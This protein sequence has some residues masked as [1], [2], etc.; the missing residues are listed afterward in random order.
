MTAARTDRGHVCLRC[1]ARQPELER[2]A[3]CGSEELLDMSSPSAR[4]LLVRDV[5]QRGQRALDA[6]VF[7]LGV[8]IALL[9]LAMLVSLGLVALG[10][11][12]PSPWL[13]LVASGVI[14][15]A[16][17]ARLIVAARDT[18]RD[19]RSNPG[20]F[21]PLLDVIEAPAVATEGEGRVA[22]RVRALRSITSP[23]H[24]TPCVAVRVAGD[25]DA[26]AIDD[27]DCAA[28]ELVDDDDQTVARFEGGSAAVEL[29]VDATT[30]SRARPDGA[31]RRFLTARVELSTQDEARVAEA[32]LRAGEWVSL[33]GPCVEVVEATGYRGARPVK[34]FRGAPERPVVV[35]VTS[36]VRVA[37]D[38]EAGDEAV[39]GGDASSARRAS[40]RE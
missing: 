28:F 21:W 1:L 32:V 15:A 22:G 16:V 20:R 34:V 3:R 27:A 6:R 29:A 2:C 12:Q 38:D 36:R 5:A 35:S 37:I 31:L 13:A 9:A 25:S 8:R 39:A 14:A 19:V 10:L 11:A 4:E 7:E 17:L 23:I 33:E 40:A 26:G 30:A 18:M 24:D